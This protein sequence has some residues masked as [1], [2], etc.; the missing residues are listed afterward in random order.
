MIGIPVPVPTG[1]QVT[2]T[3]KRHI[4]GILCDHIAAHVEVTGK[5]KLEDLVHVRNTADFY[6]SQYPVLSQ[7]MV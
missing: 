6:R 1:M 2:C 5:W 7:N 4:Q 3:C